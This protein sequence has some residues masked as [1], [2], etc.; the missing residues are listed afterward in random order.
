MGTRDAAGYVAVVRLRG[1]YQF[2]LNA[3][4]FIQNSKKKETGRSNEEKVGPCQ[5]GSELG[6]LGR[7][8]LKCGYRSQKWDAEDAESGPTARGWV[9]EGGFGAGCRD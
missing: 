3:M 5:T 4:I 1:I 2:K 6:S 7:R 8:K 9:E